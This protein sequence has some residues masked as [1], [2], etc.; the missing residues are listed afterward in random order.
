MA[1]PTETL[2]PLHRAFSLTPDHIA[3]LPADVR[4]ELL[5]YLS[6]WGNAQELLET[7]ALLRVAYGPLLFLFDYEARAQAQIGQF[8][9]A[10]HTIERR[11]RRS[12]TIAGLAFEARALYAAGYAG[13]ALAAAATLCQAYPHQALAVA[14]AAEVFAAAGDTARGQILLEDFLTQRPGDPEAGLALAHIAL[15]AGRTGLADQVLRGLGAGVSADLDERQAQRLA[16]LHHALGNQ[17]SERAVRLDLEKRRLLRLNALRARLAPILDVEQPLLADPEQLHRLFSGPESI[18]ISDRERR[19]IQIEA[20]RH[21]GFM[22][23]REGQA[24][25]IATVLRCESI[26]VVMPTGAGKSLCYQLPALMLPRATLVISPLIALMKDQVEGLPAAARP[27]AT[28][29]NST[30]SE[31]E[32]TQRLEAVAAGQ[33]KLIYAAPE[34]LRQRA[35]LRALRDA[36]ISLFVVDEAHCVSLWGHD[37]RPDYLFLQAAREELG[38]PP[39]LAITA[40][41]PPRVRDEIVDHISGAP[42]SF[43]AAFDATGKA[44]AIGAEA[45]ATRLARPRVLSLDIFRHNIHLTALQFHNEDEKLAA[46]LQ[47]VAETQGPGIVYVNS[48]HKSESLAYELRRRSIQAEAYHAGLDN[49]A[50]I[51]DR[52]MSNQCRVVVATIAFGMGIDKAD[53]R[54]IVHFHPSRS[55]ASYYQEVG[56]A[57]RD[58]K[59]SQGVLFYSNND[60]ANLRRWAKA[61][62]FSVEF[63]ERVYAAVASQLDIVLDAAPGD[64][65]DEAQD[66][67]QD[68]ADAES[69]AGV[70]DTRRIQQV[71]DADEVS[72]RVAI[73]LL[74]HVD[75]LERSFDFPQETAVS[76]PSRPRAARAED[77]P[78][79]ET[80]DRLLKGLALRP[81]QTAAFKTAD[82]AAFMVW[83]LHQAETN[84]LQVEAQSKLKLKFARRALLVVM[85]P[86]PADMPRRLERVL[87][88]SS[89][90]A[91]RRIDEIVG[92][93]TADSCRHGYIS[94]HFGSPPR[95]HCDVCDNCTGVR[96]DL[97]AADAVQHV[98]VDDADI[99]PMILDCLVSLPKAVGRSGL[100]RVLAGSLRA[101]VKPDQARHHGRL[102]ALGEVTIVQY[103]DDLIEAHRLRPFE[104]NGYP[105][106][107]PTLKGRTEAETWLANNP[108]LAHMDAPPADIAAPDAAETAEAPRAADQYTALQRALWSWR[109]RMAEQ[110]GQPPYMILGNDLMRRIAETRPVG[111][112]ELAALPGI[113]EQ[114]LAHYGPAILDLIRLNPEQADDAGLFNQQRAA[115][116]AGATGAQAKLQPAQAPS[117]PA[118]VTRQIYVK[119]QELRQKVAVAER[120]NQ[121]EIAGNSLLKAIAAAAPRTVAEL[122][123]IP[124]F[125]SSGLRPSAGKICAIA[126]AAWERHAASD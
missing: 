49:R 121:S 54:F 25:A 29:I 123:S 106:L 73:S 76:L 30:L 82:I 92:Y 96:P 114:R 117:V 27:V 55:L 104:Q 112:E 53:I 4:D 86:R 60:W 63:L 45:A 2:T 116:A 23:L 14:A 58:G 99:E 16:E 1:D 71:L 115:E 93:A 89:A 7:V 28:F 66:G 125:R 9:Q 12:V 85:P 119:L 48:R 88:Q 31:E 98:L 84:L 74:E 75:L 8:D 91:Q 102:K 68:G 126:E 94:A 42:P 61:D 33:Y 11:Q 50:E 109:R 57:G 122:E 79:N 113:G 62:G 18:E 70:V 72:V 34:R 56:R 46:L 3:A 41:A 78:P 111:L 5:E 120:C 52:F 17:E 87:A 20:V 67:A 80:L 100:A 103:I 81:G 107:A 101:P 44:N 105:V 36:G 13:H 110:Q 22:E 24:E 90:V 47:F 77:D 59:P 83:P 6:L 35:F 38:N 37:F 69:A 15:T 124:G 51:Q 32:L 65:H 10:L 19:K 108:D 95:T 40:T 21:F 64:A 43:D 26:L 97:P 39:A 118:T